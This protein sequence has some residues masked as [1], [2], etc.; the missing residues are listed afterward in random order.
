M[1]AAELNA[2]N[3]MLA[4][5]G[6]SP[7]ENI[8]IMPPSGHTARLI[9]NQTSAAIQTEGHWFN[10]EGSY[11]LVPDAAGEINLPPN[12][13]SVDATD[14]T[15]DVIARG[16][17]LYDK[18]RQSY[19]FDSAVECDVILLLPWEELP[20][21]A[22]WYITAAATE[23][24]CESFPGSPGVTEARDRNLRR[25]LASFRRAEVE[26]GDYSLLKNTSIQYNLRRT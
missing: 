8:E 24:F 22:R 6:E 7:L 26:N 11:R 1:P 25:A 4:A 2:V 21:V 23:L 20:P 17:R 3:E 14:D 15:I 16:S 9:L 19:T 5:I 10:Q 12:I 18:T 13:L